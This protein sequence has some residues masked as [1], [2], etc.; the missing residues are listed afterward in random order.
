MQ[1]IF[2]S[3]FTLVTIL[4]ACRL[5]RLSYWGVVLL[6]LLGLG[7]FLTDITTHTNLHF[8]QLN[9]S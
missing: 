8:S 5:P 2:F 3:L 7:L 9:F 6:L 1:F 4:T